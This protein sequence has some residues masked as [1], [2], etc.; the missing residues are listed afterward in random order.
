MQLILRGFT[1]SKQMFPDVFCWLWRVAFLYVERN[2]FS[3][4]LSVQA[5]ISARSSSVSPAVVN[6]VISSINCK[7]HFLKKKLLLN[8]LLS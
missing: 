8:L 7:W 6:K 1:V 5:P 2:C 4:L 3:T